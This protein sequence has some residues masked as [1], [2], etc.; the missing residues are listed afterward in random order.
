LAG[1][2]HHRGERRELSDKRC[3]TLEGWLSTV[4]RLRE[5]I[6][7]KDLRMRPTPGFW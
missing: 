2:E 3:L 6:G 5:P 4:N 7:P 1:S